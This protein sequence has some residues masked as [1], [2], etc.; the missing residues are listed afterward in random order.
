M[1]TLDFLS[2]LIMCLL[3]G[4]DFI[5][6]KQALEVLN[7]LFFTSIRFFIVGFALFPFIKKQIPAHLKELF[8]AGIMMVVV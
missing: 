6:A 7:P 2:I 8:F 4:L 5:F 3:W 1:K